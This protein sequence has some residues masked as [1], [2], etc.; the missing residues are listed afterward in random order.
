MKCGGKALRLPLGRILFT[1]EAASW[2]PFLYM[3][4]GEQNILHVQ[5]TRK[6]Y[7]FYQ[8]SLQSTHTEFIN[9]C[10]FFQNTC[11]FVF[12]MYFN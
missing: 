8:G 2:N 5:N 12:L 6:Y 9:L 1:S 4:G 11:S 3:S 10:L 7:K